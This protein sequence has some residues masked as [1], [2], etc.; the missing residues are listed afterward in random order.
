MASV[1]IVSSTYVLFP[2]ILALDFYVPVIVP[3][4]FRAVLCAKPPLLFSPLPGMI[5]PAPGVVLTGMVLGGGSVFTV[6]LS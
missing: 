1:G 2:S 6:V 5:R 3:M 4:E